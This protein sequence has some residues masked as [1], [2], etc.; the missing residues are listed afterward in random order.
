MMEF[1][2]NSI[3]DGVGS[4]IRIASRNGVKNVEQYISVNNLYNV[5]WINNYGMTVSQIYVHSKIMIV[6]DDWV[7]I[8][9]ANMND[10]SLRGD[11]DTEIAIIVKD[12]VKCTVT[13]AGKKYIGNQSCVN[14]RKMLWKEHLGLDSLFDSLLDDPY[15]CFQTLWLQTALKNRLILEQVFPLFPRDAY[16][17]YINTK[18]H[19]H[20]TTT[21]DRFPLLLQLQG[22]VVK[23]SMG[24][25]SKEHQKSYGLQ[26]II[27]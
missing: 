25:G 27:T 11:R 3:V 14:F 18:K 20:P 4:I 19:T 1:T 9:S 2:R 10:R 6:D 17:K 16:V 15:E 26:A 8:G 7:M 24:F 5:G 21:P 12:D 13:F 22:H 23:A